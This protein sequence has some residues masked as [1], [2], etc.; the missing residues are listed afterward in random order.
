MER[1]LNNKFFL[2]IV[3]RFSEY[4]QSFP[5]LLS[6]IYDKRLSQTL[7]KSK[8]FSRIYNFHDSRHRSSKKTAHRFP[9][10]RLFPGATS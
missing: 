4:F 3:I 6:R 9:F 1:L 7:L 5:I 2:L 10:P 8:S